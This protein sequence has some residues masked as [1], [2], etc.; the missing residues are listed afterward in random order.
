MALRS[1]E[2]VRVSGFSTGVPFA[3]VLL[4]MCYAILQSDEFAKRTEDALGKKTVQ[5]TSSDDNLIDDIRR[6]ESSVGDD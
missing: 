6:D 3:V 1:T 4:V 5:V 2:I